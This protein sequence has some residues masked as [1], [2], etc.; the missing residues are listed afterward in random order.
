MAA[1]TGILAV[2]YVN[3]KYY[4]MEECVKD[5]ED[6]EG[7]GNG[8]NLKWAL[9]KAIKRKILQRCKVSPQDSGKVI[10]EEIDGAKAER[11]SVVNI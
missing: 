1:A 2:A 10:R 11:L 8:V 7:R 3:K 4:A 5:K 9:V 6:S